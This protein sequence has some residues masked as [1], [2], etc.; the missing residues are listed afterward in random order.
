MEQTGKVGATFSENFGRDKV[1]DTNVT[2]SYTT[3]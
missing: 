3:D 2:I 1:S